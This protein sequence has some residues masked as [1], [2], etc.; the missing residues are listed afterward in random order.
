MEVKTEFFS[1]P[2]EL[3]ATRLAKLEEMKA[4][5]GFTGTRE[6]HK[7]IEWIDGLIEVNQRML[8]LVRGLN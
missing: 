4:K 2:T 7:S 6:Y 3:V 8:K 1:S 5:I